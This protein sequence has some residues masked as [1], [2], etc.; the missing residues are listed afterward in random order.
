M[1]P[2]FAD[3]PTPS[4]FD[5]RVRERHLRSGVLTPA[6]VEQHLAALPD[7]GDQSEELGYAQPALDDP[8]DE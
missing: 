3:S 5:V 4:T 6:A 1:G 7:V 2:K 8:A